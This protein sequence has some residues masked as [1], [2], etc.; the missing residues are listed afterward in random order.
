MG[1]KRSST[2]AVPTPGTTEPSESG[3]TTSPSNPLS[4]YVQ[5]LSVTSDPAMKA[6]LEAHTGKLKSDD[7]PSEKCV[8]PEE[9]LRRATAAVRDAATKHDQAVSALLRAREV[10]DK[11]TE[12]EASAALVLAKA[13]KSKLQAVRA[14][15]EMNGVIAK[16]SKESSHSNGGDTKKLISI[17]WDEDF[18]S[19]L[20][21]LEVSETER[22]DLKQ[23]ETDLKGVRDLVGNKS[24]EVETMLARMAKMQEDIMTRMAKKRKGLDGEATGSSGSGS[25]GAEPGRTQT[26]GGERLAEDIAVDEDKADA[27][28]AEEAQRL[29]AAKLAAAQAVHGAGLGGP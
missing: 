3:S 12:R 9:S 6:V 7:I 25:A 20:D 29:S 5:A 11:A 26:G 19:K 18:F 16:D 28:L 1:K 23:L 22:A 4:A 15:A 24:S 17:S 13:E 14:L 8:A 10:L 21:T 2:A 27:E